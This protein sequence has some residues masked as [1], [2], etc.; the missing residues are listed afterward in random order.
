MTVSSLLE[1][2]AACGIWEPNMEKSV[3]FDLKYQV[4][5][6]Y[7]HCMITCGYL[8]NKKEQRD[9]YLLSNLKM[10]TIFFYIY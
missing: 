7:W 1:L 5:E 10:R 4:L 3:Y 8:W 9:K 2:K 6:M